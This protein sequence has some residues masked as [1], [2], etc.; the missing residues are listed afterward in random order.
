MNKIINSIRK[1]MN[2]RYG[3]DE[4]NRDLIIC[5]FIISLISSVFR[6]DVLSFVSTIIIIYVFY[7]M[8]SKQNNKRLIENR[9]YREFKDKVLTR[10][11]FWK[12][13][14][15]DRKSY[16]YFTCPNC[17]QKVRIPVNQGKIEITCPK[18]RQIF[19]KRT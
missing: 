14:W 12:R 3:V 13:E 10:F 9:K 16:R 19:E 18:C 5:G 11:K 2:G 7:R 1:F 6:I 8:L 17:K 15:D 4:L